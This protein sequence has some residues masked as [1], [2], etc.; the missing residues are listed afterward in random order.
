MLELV[1]GLGIVMLYRFGEMHPQHLV[2][3]VFRQNT[4]CFGK[5]P[6]TIES[7]QLVHH[8]RCMQLELRQFAGFRENLQI[9]KHLFAKPFLLM[10]RSNR[11]VIDIE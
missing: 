7:N 4:M 3:P 11:E 8:F 5:A 1:V 10:I 9:R 2:P 6:A